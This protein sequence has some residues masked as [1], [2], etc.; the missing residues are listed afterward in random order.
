MAKAEGVGEPT[1]SLLLRQLVDEGN[2]PEPHRGRIEDEVVDVVDERDAPSRAA[3]AHGRQPVAP[4]GTELIS[5]KQQVCDGQKVNAIVLSF[6]TESIIGIKLII[7][8]ATNQPGMGNFMAMRAG[9][10]HWNGW[11]SRAI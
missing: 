10:R 5:C 1:L 2:L 6:V 9:R 7:P 8:L 3:L 11:V 4:L